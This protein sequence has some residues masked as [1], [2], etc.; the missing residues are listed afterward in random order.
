[1][2]TLKR[3][4]P[5]IVADDGSVHYPSVTSPPDDSI[6][7]CYM[8]PSR[9]IPVIF[10][11]GVMGTNLMDASAKKAIWLADSTW[12]VVKDW[13]GRGPK[14]R[15]EGLGPNVTSVFSDGEIPAGTKRT[16]KELHRRGWGE[17]ANMSYG[18]FLVW[19]ENALNDADETTDYGRQGL[20][21]SLMK[22][23]LAED[24]KLRRWAMTKWP[25]RTN[26][27]SRF[28]RW[29]ITG[30]NP[31]RCPPSAWE[32]RSRNSWRTTTA[33]PTDAATSF[34]SRIRWAAWSRAT[35]PSL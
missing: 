23:A 33:N 31:M 27:S 11:P 8:V 28:M 25:Y 9:I 19:L 13:G 21:A 35:I 22:Q 10:V 12:S 34:S 32:A 4:I 7:V 16:E 2:A 14:K 30:W 20:R 26:T 1:M 3:I 18:E 15:K 5:A 24:L 17:V 6:A 29:A